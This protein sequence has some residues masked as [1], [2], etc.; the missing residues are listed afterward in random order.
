MRQKHEKANRYVKVQPTQVPERGVKG[1]QGKKDG[2][3][4]VSAISQKVSRKRLSK[5]QEFYQVVGDLAQW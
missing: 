2:T 1:A 3:K 5:S 4:S